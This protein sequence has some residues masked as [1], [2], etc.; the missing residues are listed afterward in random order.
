MGRRLARGVDEAGPL[1]HGLLD[2]HPVP[3]PAGEGPL[4]LGV[5][6]LVDE[7][8]FAQHE[9][10][11]LLLGRGLQLRESLAHGVGAEHHVDHVGNVALSGAL[12]VELAQVHERLVCLG[13]STFTLVQHRPECE[14]GRRCHDT[15]GHRGLPREQ[16]EPLEVVD[17][18]LRPADRHVGDCGEFVDARRRHA[19]QQLVHRG[20]LVIKS[21]RLEHASLPFPRRGRFATAH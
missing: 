8:D 2:D 15:V 14:R 1:E 21:D 9:H 11:H 20:V 3:H 7:G 12:T 5:L 18:L 6:A 19:K 4:L 10:A 13:Q 16:P 17:H